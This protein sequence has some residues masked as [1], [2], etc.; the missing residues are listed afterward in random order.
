[1]DI[2]FN[3]QYDRKTFLRALRLVQH[4]SWVDRA[5]R[6]AALGLALILLGAA[7]YNWA[8]N[9]RLEYYQAFL[10]LPL[11]LYAA[12]PWLSAWWTAYRLFQGRPQRV[13]SGRANEQGITLL[14]KIAP[15]KQRQI[16]W[17]AF[18]RAGHSPD[19]IG[20]L[21]ND[22]SLWVFCSAFFSNKNQWKAFQQLVQKHIL[23]P[24]RKR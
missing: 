19:M 2:P 20:L 21:T 17:E 14:S 8:K 23:E 24:K 4:T 22:G 1:M 3:G 15:G 5:L 12:A 18:Q 11:L 16:R 10:F 9:N 7:C 13:I 6:I